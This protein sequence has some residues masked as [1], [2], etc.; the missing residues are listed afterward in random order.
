MTLTTKTSGMIFKLSYIV[1]KISGFVFFSV[2]RK[3]ADV[4]EFHRSWIDYAI[5]IVSFTFSAYACSEGSSTIFEL[6]LNSIVLNLGRKFLWKLSMSSVIVW[7]CVHFVR[8][9]D[10][11]NIMVNL[12]WMDRQVDTLN[13]LITNLSMEIYRKIDF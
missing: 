4:L 1:L 3:A 13:L 7:K 10:V 9:R 6:K 5:F 2:R 11:F 8:G 12:K